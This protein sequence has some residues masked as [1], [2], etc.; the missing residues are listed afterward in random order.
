[1]AAWREDHDYAVLCSPYFQYPR[2]QSQV[3]AQAVDNNVCLLSWEHLLSLLSRG[4]KENEHINL[5]SL[6]G[7]GET[8]SHKVVVAEKKKCFI[9]NFDAFLASSVGLTL[10]DFDRVLALCVKDIARRGEV[11]KAY[12][13][14]ERKRITTYTREQAISELI[15]SRKIDERI[16]QIDAYI[17]GIQRD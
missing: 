13:E 7:F 6:W 9:R 14:N 15:K 4:I 16:Q 17:R 8:L 3:Y 5:S 2:S 12:W 10:L 11:E 1:M